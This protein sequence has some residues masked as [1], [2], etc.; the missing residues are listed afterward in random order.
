MEF[1][2]I[3]RIKHKS[4]KILGYYLLS[5]DKAEVWRLRSESL[6]HMI[7]TGT[8]VVSNLKLTHDGR[9]L[10]IGEGPQDVV[11]IDKLISENSILTDTKSIVIPSNIT[12][13]DGTAFKNCSSLEGNK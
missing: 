1:R 12:T 4:G 5:K 2:C 13:I 3:K 7:E 6:K 10:V 9:L 8:I 11:L